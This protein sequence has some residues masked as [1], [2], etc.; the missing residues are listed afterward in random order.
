M[1]ILQVRFVK[2]KTI[3]FHNSK[4][5]NSLYYKMMKQDGFM[6]VFQNVQKIN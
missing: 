5:V 6:N 2:P 4:D 1:L 3:I